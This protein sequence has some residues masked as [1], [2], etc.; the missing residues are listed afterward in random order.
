MSHCDDC[1][2]SSLA[3]LPPQAAPA[4]VVAIIGPPN[5]GKSTLFNRL[6]G[7]RQKVANFPG[8]TV[9]Q[10]SG[11]VKLAGGKDARLIDLPGLYSL[12]ARSEDEQITHDVLKG[13]RPGVPRPDAVMLILDSTNLGRHLLLAAPILALGLPTLIVL[14]MAD[15]PYGPYYP[16]DDAVDWVGMSLYHWGS[17]YPWGANAAL[18]MLPW[19]SSV[20]GG[21]A[22]IYRGRAERERLVVRVRGSRRRCE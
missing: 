3:V 21:A 4:A 20:R 22:G 18:L 11:H 12:A 14:N 17:S 9:E 10:H 6:T 1:G 8:V 16:G 2:S 5:S 13:L 19:V 15:D 7:L